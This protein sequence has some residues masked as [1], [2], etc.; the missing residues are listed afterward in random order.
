MVENLFTTVFQ[1]QLFLLFVTVSV[2]VYFFARKKKYICTQTFNILQKCYL[3]IKETS[4]VSERIKSIFL[5]RRL[6]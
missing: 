3:K 1:S 4:I 6:K 5:A 2:S